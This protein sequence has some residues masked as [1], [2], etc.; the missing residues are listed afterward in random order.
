MISIL[1]AVL[2]SQCFA[3][4]GAPCTPYP[5]VTNYVR[6]SQDLK[7]GW[8][9][10]GGCS[11]DE[12][13]APA[14]ACADSF[15]TRGCGRVTAGHIH[16][17]AVGEGENAFVYQ[18]NACPS[19]TRS[20]GAFLRARDGG[21]ATPGLYVGGSVY[22][23]EV[24][25][26]TRSKVE[27]VTSGSTT[28]AIGNFGPRPE[29]D[30]DF[31]QADCQDSAALLPPVVTGAVPLRREAGCVGSNVRK[32]A[33]LGDS[34]MLASGTGL[35][36]VGVRVAEA[37][38]P[39]YAAIEAGVAGDTCAAVRARWPSVLDAGVTHLVVMC[40]VNDARTGRT[41]SQAWGDLSA[42]LEDALDAGVKVRP[43]LT[44]N[45]EGSGDAD[46]TKVAMVN[47]LRGSIASWC[48][49]HDIACAD[50]AVALQ[51]GDA[52]K[53]DL[54]QDGTHPNAAGSVLFVTHISS[55]PQRYVE[56]W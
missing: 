29:L 41:A 55:W 34:I 23:Y 5:A 40:G 45:F 10:A 51:T 26:W 46:S 56:G 16:C 54:R 28:F 31:W 52:L 2:V 15:N 1:A 50:P 17:P 53:T 20:A 9:S 18:N 7:W 33:G 42:V 13:V 37:L 4:G 49:S 22:V 47:T 27:S 8:S 44:L 36:Q 38:G 24:N 3:D 11:V 43:V 25:G 14:P 19:G 21:T 35:P 30:V 12:D 6:S 39:D 32:V 48:S